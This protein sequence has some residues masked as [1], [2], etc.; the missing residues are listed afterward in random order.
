MHGCRWRRCHCGIGRLLHAGSGRIVKSSVGAHCWIFKAFSSFYSCIAN[1]LDCVL[2]VDSLHLFKWLVL[3]STQSARGTF[4]PSVWVGRVPSLRA[5][6]RA[7]FN[8]NAVAYFCFLYKNVHG[9]FRLRR[10]LF[11]TTRIKNLKLYKCPI[12]SLYS[13]VV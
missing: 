5:H 7:L 9:S 4:I 13:T 8:Q 6:A 1:C 2:S 12:D 10:L 11:D 3:F